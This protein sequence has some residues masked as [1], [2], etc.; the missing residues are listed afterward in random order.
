MARKS[1]IQT[2]NE[3][4]A[5]N[6]INPENIEGMFAMADDI[7]DVIDREKKYA[8]NSQY[9]E[10]SK[11]L[12]DQEK[13]IK[14]CQEQ[15]INNL[16]KIEIRPT[17]NR[18]L[19]KPFDYN[20][21]QKIEVKNGVITDIGGL[22]PDVIFNPDTG[23]YQEREQHIK[24]SVVVEVG[25]EVKWAQVGDTVFCMKNCLSPVPFFKQGLWILNEDN[26]MAI[27]ND[28]FSEREWK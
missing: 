14:E 17:K 13:A 5:Q 3:R 1:L 19:V 8:F 2:E 26:I 22:N 25:P 18:V 11:E 6:V 9:E 20:P 4:I 27:V 28:N 12:A 23:K 10:Q 24:V 16:D 21:F 15:V 7:D